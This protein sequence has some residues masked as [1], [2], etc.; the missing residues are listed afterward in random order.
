M[1]CSENKMR[2]ILFNQE[3]GFYRFSCLSNT[4]IREDFDALRELCKED[5]GMSFVSCSENPTLLSFFV[6]I[7]LSSA[8][9][10]IVAACVA[11][12]VY[13]KR[14]FACFQRSS[15]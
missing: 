4:F 14:T 11:L 5:D 15:Q 12:Y 6:F 7:G 3:N 13:K 9:G 8:L 1:L 10:A 2:S